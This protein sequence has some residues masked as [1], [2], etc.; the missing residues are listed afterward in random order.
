MIKP[1]LL[2]C[3]LCLCQNLEKEVRAV[4]T[5]QDGGDTAGEHALLIGHLQTAIS[6]LHPKLCGRS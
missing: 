3:T 1:V 2:K 4:G 5:L 6:L